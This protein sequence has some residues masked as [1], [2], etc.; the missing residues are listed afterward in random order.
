M[1]PKGYRDLPRACSWNFVYT[2]LESSGEFLLI[3][4]KKFIMIQ[5]VLIDVPRQ[6]FEPW[7]T[8]PKTVVL[9]ITPSG[10]N[11]WSLNEWMI[12]FYFSFKNQ[13][14]SNLEH[15]LGCIPCTQVSWFRL[16]TYPPPT[17]LHISQIST[18]PLPRFSTFPR[19]HV[20]TSPR[21]HLSAFSNHPIT[22]FN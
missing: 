22:L 3:R 1:H 2:S 12:N 5:S 20:S 18:S 6:G 9:S 14:I 7:P 15:S 16:S 4:I 17:T 13:I 10:Q 19:F 8:D 11:E 21:L